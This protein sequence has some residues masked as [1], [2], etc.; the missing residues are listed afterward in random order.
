MREKDNYTVFAKILN[1]NL[2]KL[3]QHLIKTLSLVCFKLKIATPK[4][5]K[6][7][8]KY[9]KKNFKNK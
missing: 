9:L 8:V 1:L 7:L 5:S 4:D 3:I 2:R 6:I